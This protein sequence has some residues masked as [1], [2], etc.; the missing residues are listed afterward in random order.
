MST[1]TAPAA[2]STTEAGGR[3]RSR[4]LI[5]ALAVTQTVGYGVLYYV[6]S[7][8]LAPMAADLHTTSAAVTGALTV[9]VLTT[10]AA[11]VPVGR[12]LDRHGGRG[13]MTAGSILGTGAV[14][15]WSQITDIRQL[16]AVFVVLGIASAMA[17]YEAAFA[18]VIAVST[19]ARRSGALLAITVVAGFASTIFLPLAAN[20]Q[21]HH[22]W[23][24][25]LIIL[26]L[27]YCAI[28]VPLHALT[29]PP[30][31]RPHPASAALD[32][33]ARRTAVRAALRHRGFWL[34][35]AAFVIHG[36]AV[37]V[38]S[39]HLITYLT[40]LGHPATFAAAVAGLLGVMS[41]TG[42]IVTTALTRHRSIAMVTASVFAVQAVAAASLPLL[43]QHRLGAIVCVVLFGTGFGVGTIAR[44]AILAERYG[45]TGY[46]TI[47]SALTLPTTIAKA[48]TP[49]AAAAAYA[50]AGSYV[51]VL[52]AV[53]IACA[54]AATALGLA[55]GPAMSR[56][57]VEG[58][59]IRVV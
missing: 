40:T 38:I 18:V 10:A 13:L 2:A 5:A 1:I 48:T 32:H 39:V 17:L 15:A 26:A 6:F 3:R 31:P 55:R 19:P 57:S 33:A 42:R 7:V 24:T 41:V 30:Q 34:L 35:T 37:A 14:L 21:Q 16:Y 43:G 56:A 59:S 50:V 25:T 53:A 47:A 45:T 54:I 49:L 20:L 28:A 58:E 27:G 12:W 44:P 23:R 46:A 8:F 22:G 36:S 4:P 9:S 51:P 29:V 11:A 52:A